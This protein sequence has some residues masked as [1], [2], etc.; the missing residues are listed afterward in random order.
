MIRRAAV[1]TVDDL[2]EASELIR[3]GHAFWDALRGT[4][5]WPARTDLDPL[6]VPRHL[7]PHMLMIDVE[8]GPPRRFRWRLIGTHITSVMQRD[9]TGRYFDELYSASEFERVTIG[10]LTVFETGRACHNITRA[11]SSERAF[12]QMEAIDMPF[13]RTGEEMD[14]ILA[15]AVATEGRF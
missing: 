15:F 8:R 11:P 1:E 14:M 6:D 9:S 10:P 12:I 4:R 3:E 2:E 5:P 13:S 7:L